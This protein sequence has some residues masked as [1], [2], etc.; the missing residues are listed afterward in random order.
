M[1]WAD[2]NRVL[3]P[4]ASAEHGRWSTSRVEVARGPMMAFSDTTVRT[5]TVMGPTQMM[6][7]E[8]IVNAVGLVIDGGLGPVLLIE[9]TI[10]MAEAW[11]TDRLDT[12][13][14]DTPSLA[15]KVAPARSRDAYN[16]RLYK[17]FPGGHITMAGAN[18]P[19][20]LAMRSIKF[21]F[22]DEVDK[23]PVS[24]GG[25][26]G[27]GDP[28]TLAEERASTFHDGKCVRVCSPTVKGASRIEAS[29]AESDQRRFFT[30]CP[31]CGHLQVLTW[32]HVKW[33]AGRPSTAAIWCAA[34]GAR[35]SERERLA[36]LQW[37]VWR[38]TAPFTCC[39]EEQ[40]PRR[41]AYGDDKAEP[42]VA[43]IGEGRAWAWDDAAGVGRSL[44]RHCGRPSAFGGHAGF[45]AWKAHSPW[46]RDGLGYL[47][48]KW[49]AVQAH[50]ALK[51][52][53]VNTQLAASFEDEGATVDAAALTGRGEAWDGADGAAVPAGVL[54]LT[55]GVDVHPD[56][57]E[58]ELV[59]WGMD[60]E[61]WSLEAPVFWGDPNGRAVWD[62]L[63]A[64][65]RAP[66][67]APGGFGL[68]IQATA[69]D[70]GGWNTQRVYDFCARRA[71]RRVW[72]V[73]GVGGEGKPI[74]RRS[75]TRAR[76]A[77]LF[78]V[79]VDDAKQAI[80][81]AL[82]VEAPG[83]SYC[84]FPAGRPEDWYA[85]LAAETRVTTF[86]NGFPVRV[87]MKKAGARNEALDCRV[88]AYAAL[89]SLNIN[90]QRMAA[91]K[92]VAL[93]LG[94]AQQDADHST[95]RGAQPHA[96]APAAVPKPA[97]A[98]E[99]G[100]PP[101]PAVEQP[102]PRPMPRSPVRRPQRQVFA[103]PFVG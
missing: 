62:D 58:A 50:P 17:R 81:D 15:G 99:P 23:Y 64:W 94:G 39:D 3:S 67:T 24:A 36:A 51:R 35:W 25:P 10:T 96:E 32:D 84:H 92:Q 78:T 30:P 100:S 20:S 11:S 68:V 45:H 60:E 49:E 4:E 37:S 42:P 48:A 21:V 29:Y 101:A 74:W 59:G 73:K 7:T 33:D 28:I 69:I 5:I 88:Y 93:P 54:V 55:A 52:T 80:Y 82:R 89:K 44:C 65:L 90:W 97:P 83:P 14:R 76:G 75:K 86:R 19:A 57:L 47:A 103:S 27:E 91:H 46:E 70:S 102:A 13:L 95:N 12:M 2:S 79:G 31:H 56:R 77:T 8:F 71:T 34:C 85:Q 26:D 40:D 1:E 53:F 41:N 66:R 43:A 87:W 98:G 63:D 9:P 22:E 18:S 16:K 72:A 61:S 6:K 38:Q